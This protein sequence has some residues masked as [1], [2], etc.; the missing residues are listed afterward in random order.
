MSPLKPPEN[1]LSKRLRLC[2]LAREI[3][4]PQQRCVSDHGN[5][6]KVKA[7]MTLRVGAGYKLS[8]TNKATVL[9]LDGP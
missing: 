6:M 2:A 5:E 7:T 1:E 9:I 8:K 3:I 4:L